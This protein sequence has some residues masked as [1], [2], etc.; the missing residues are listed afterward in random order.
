MGLSVPDVFYYGNLIGD[1]GLNTSGPYATLAE[2]YSATKAV[3]DDPAQNT[4]PISSRFDHNR[5]NIHDDK[6]SEAVTKNFF[7]TLLLLIAPR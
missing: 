3:A 5:D 2:D 7:R 6:D 4:A 1:T